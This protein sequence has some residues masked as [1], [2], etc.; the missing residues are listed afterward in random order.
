MSSIFIMLMLS[1]VSCTRH[2]ECDKM[3]AKADSL[4]NMAPDSALRILDTLEASSTGFPQ[5]TLRRWQLL[6]LMAQNKCDTVF[7]SDS[8][9]LILTDYYDSHGTSNERMMSHYLLGRAHSDMG[10]SPEAMQCYQ[11]ALACA[12]TASVDCDWWNLSRVCLQLAS[13]YYESYLPSEMMETLQL[14]HSS[15]LHAGDTITSIYA[16]ARLSGAYELK[17]MKDS[18][19]I[20]TRK[21][22]RLFESV[23]RNDL[24][25]RM[26][27]LLIEDE[28]EKGNK[29]EATKLVKY[30]EG[31]SGFF[32][33]SHEIESGME[34]YYYSKGIYYLGMEQ[35]D[36]AEW[37]FR[38]LLHKA[39]DTNDLHAAYLGL[40][41]KY[42]LTGPQDSLVK[43]ATLSESSNDSLYQE[44]YKANV[45]SLQKRFNYSRH[46]EKEQQLAISNA[47][48]DKVVL[49]CIFTFVLALF[50]A[51]AFYYDKKKK[52]EAMLKEYLSDIQR[53]KD[54]K[55]EKEKLLSSKEV[56]IVSLSDEG[57]MLRADIDEKNQYILELKK[58]LDEVGKITTE[59]INAKDEEIKQLSAKY[60]KYDKFIANKTKEEVVR[61]IQK[62]PIVGRLNFIVLHPLNPPTAE[63]WAKLDSLFREKHPNFP[64]TLQDKLNLSANEYRVCQLIFAGIPPKGISVLMGFEKSNITNMRKRLLVKT[65]GKNGKAS[66]FDQFL[67]SI[68][69]L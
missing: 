29:E 54:L 11:D 49:A 64:A 22:A 23:G 35:A 18:A 21:A 33:N 2:Q 9:Q 30:Y 66:D 17:E 1:S 46:L 10:E 6:R 68:P 42:L 32:D 52:R 60:K 13:E 43:Y 38:K 31:S 27:S 41:K 19:A 63:E 62:S 7:H 45:H 16:I 65:T 56:T 47:R 39:Q 24:A 67:F 36:S 40:K 37:M 3:L 34:I 55:A 14:S 25:S 5:R 8:L 4:M 48:K 26:L 28:M 57:I 44:N 20:V 53:L 58:K 51:S 15:A 69:V 59:T 61:A 12:D 50:A